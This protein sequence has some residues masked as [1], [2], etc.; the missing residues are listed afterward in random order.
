MS[1]PINWAYNHWLL[2]L[3]AGISDMSFFGEAAERCLDIVARKHAR[4]EG[5]LTV[6]VAEWV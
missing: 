3:V 1:Q 5:H 4:M 6:D 2:G